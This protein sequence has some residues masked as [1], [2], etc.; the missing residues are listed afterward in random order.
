[1][2]MCFVELSFIVVLTCF[3]HPVGRSF[4]KK[5]SVVIFY[6]LGLFVDMGTMPIKVL[7]RMMSL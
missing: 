4:R 1:M 2:V 7:M 5:F 6:S 3:A